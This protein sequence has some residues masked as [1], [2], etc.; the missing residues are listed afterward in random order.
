MQHACREGQPGAE[1]GQER[2]GSLED[3]ELSNLAR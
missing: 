3:P 1:K 2:A